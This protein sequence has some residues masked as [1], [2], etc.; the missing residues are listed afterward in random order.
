MPTFLGAEIIQQLSNQIASDYQDSSRGREW[1]SGKLSGWVPKSLQWD[2]ELAGKKRAVFEGFQK[3]MGHL[4]MQLSQY[5]VPEVEVAVVAKS[6]KEESKQ[7][8]SPK[9]KKASKKKGSKKS[10]SYFDDHA[11]AKVVGS[12]NE[13]RVEKIK[14]SKVPASWKN[15]VVEDPTKSQ[16]VW[17]EA[18]RTVVEKA[19]TQASDI[20]LKSKGSTKGKHNYY[21]KKLGH[22]L[23]YSVVQLFGFSMPRV[24]F[25]APFDA[26]LPLFFLPYDEDI[27]SKPL[28]DS[29]NREAVQEYIACVVSLIIKDFVEYYAFKCY[30]VNDSQSWASVWETCGLN[31]NQE[32]GQEKINTCI[33]KLVKGLR[34]KLELLLGKKEYN[35]S[36]AYV[37]SEFH[38]ELSK[39]NGEVAKLRKEKAVGVPLSV[40]YS[41][42]VFRKNVAVQSGEGGYED[43]L[44]ALMNQFD[45][46]I[47]DLEAPKKKDELTEAD[48][49]DEMSAFSFS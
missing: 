20:S 15:V 35:F 26:E 4:T 34:N 2:E 28:P 32:V 29:D 5:F 14:K 27:L 49:S 38:Q 12:D 48:P 19:H 42:G 44:A 46:A 39:A 37:L 24:G 30:R 18:I 3:N 43:R 7:D 21:F 47:K 22:L 25:K 6:V 45:A 8:K 9:A 11:P 36:K 31:P 1:G 23:G 17:A 13:K 40:P 33:P 16:R 10:L 41:F